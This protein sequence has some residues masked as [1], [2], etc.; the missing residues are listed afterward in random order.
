[1]HQAVA[2][3]DGSLAKSTLPEPG[4][5][6][7]AGPLVLLILIRHSLEEPVEITFSAAGGCGERPRRERRSPRSG[8]RGR[9]RGAVRLERS[10]ESTAKLLAE[11]CL[12]QEACG[13][14]MRSVGREPFPD[15]VAAAL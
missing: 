13:V 9:G 11:P 12:K 10:V 8:H 7:Q 6:H 3:A 1:M 15:P 14:A 4:N 2:T 5:A